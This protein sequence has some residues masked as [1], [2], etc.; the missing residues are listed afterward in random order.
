VNLRRVGAYGP[1]GAPKVHHWKANQNLK[2]TQI[3]MKLIATNVQ[4]TVMIV[5]LER[6]NHA[7]YTP[8]QKADGSKSESELAETL[9]LHFDGSQKV[10]LKGKDAQAFLKELK[11]DL[12]HYANV[13]LFKTD[14]SA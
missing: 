10:T 14:E 1:A 11:S 13:S 12:P 4:H 2:G 6:L 3:G 9:E 8:R 5:N 7:I